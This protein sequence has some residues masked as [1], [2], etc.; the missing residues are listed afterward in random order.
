MMTMNVRDISD[1][2]VIFK[3]RF[4]PCGIAVRADIKR[5]MFSKGKPRGFGVISTTSGNHQDRIKPFDHPELRFTDD[6]QLKTDDSQRG[7]TL[8][9]P[10][11]TGLSS[12]NGLL[13][14]M[15]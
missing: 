15:P 8:R 13:E 3:T 6:C 9:F 12:S 4:Q 1:R 10:Y 14:Q 5:C 2:N 11:G 7:C